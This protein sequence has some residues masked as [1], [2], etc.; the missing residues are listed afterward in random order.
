MDFFRGNNEADILMKLF[1]FTASSIQSLRSASRATTSHLLCPTAHLWHTQLEVVEGFLLLVVDP[2]PGEKPHRHD[3]YFNS[4]SATLT[5]IEELIL[6][7]IVHL[8]STG[9]IQ[10]QSFKNVF[11]VYYKINKW[12]CR[13]HYLNSARYEVPSLSGY[14]IQITPLSGSDT[15]T[16]RASNEAVTAKYKKIDLAT[17]VVIKGFSG[18]R[19]SISTCTES[20]KKSIFS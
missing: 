7:P 20:T 16:M 1:Q 15:L 18:R 2:R 10:N 6:L 3:Q 12:R 11:S 4:C 5:H 9:L 8:K 19:A 13:K 17:E 14:P